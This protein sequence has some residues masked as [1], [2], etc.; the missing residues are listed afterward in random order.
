M[1]KVFLGGTCA[2]TTWRNELESELEKHLINYFNPVVE[3]WTPECQAIEEN[4]KN[5]LCNVHLYVIT[6]EMQGV[7][8][9]AEIVHSAHLANMYGTSVDKVVFL[10]KQSNWE[11]HA[12]KSFNATMTLVRNI[13]PHNSVVGYWGKIQD[14]VDAIES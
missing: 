4:E 13:A 8:S 14:I 5:K 2:G 12:I 9:I 6:P 10:V 1:D 11:K 7:Y 3:D